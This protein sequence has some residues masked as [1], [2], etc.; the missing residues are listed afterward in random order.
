MPTTEDESC[1]PSHQELLTA[2]ERAR[3][4]WERNPGPHTFAVLE[5]CFQFLLPELG[6]TGKFDLDQPGFLYSFTGTVT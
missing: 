1:R 3:E 6:R 4:T 2:Y 5:T